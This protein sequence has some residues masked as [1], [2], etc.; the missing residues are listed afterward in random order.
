MLI[1]NLAGLALIALIVWWFWW[2]RQGEAVAATEILVEDGVY[3]PSRIA[4]EAGQ[5]TTLV[6]LRRDP[7]ACAE[8]VVFPDLNVAQHLV[9]DRRIPVE[10]PALEPGEYEFTCQMAMYRGQL[11]VR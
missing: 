10:L 4:I 9:V 8:Q 6:F 7:T 5:P 11:V 3:T 1:V 2:P